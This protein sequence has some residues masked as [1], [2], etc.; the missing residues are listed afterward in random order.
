MEK[1]K[2]TCP[3]CKNT[4][5]EHT[6]YNLRDNKTLKV[7]KCKNCSVCF[8]SSFEHINENFYQEGK[9]ASVMKNP[10]TWLK[11]AEI[12]DKR[13]FKFLKNTIKGKKYL[14]FGC[15]AGGV[16]L[17]FK[18][19]AQVYGVE[20]CSGLKEHYKKNN[21]EVF[22]NI[23]E[24]NEKF[25][26]IS[27]FHVL[28][29]LSEPKEKIKELISFLNE[30]GK[31]IIEVPSGDDA[32][33]TLYKCKKFIDF[34]HWSCHLYS[35]SKK[36]IKEILKNIPNIKIN[37]IKNIS[38]FGLANHLYWILKGKKGGQNIWKFLN[39]FDFLYKPFLKLIQKS[40]TLIICITKT[41]Q[42]T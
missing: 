31:L 38:R 37:Y 25:D 5:V 21:L 28:E 23:N 15:G 12:D 42:N 14:D 10:Q 18:D 2:R 16:L 41:T 39:K 1:E 27:M 7:L 40:D 3:I 26:V 34:T 22:E 8:L 30:N 13:R 6:N 24:T 20:K 19:I 36:S 32:L 33:I 4:K 17:N 35:F 29:H 9:M 11:N